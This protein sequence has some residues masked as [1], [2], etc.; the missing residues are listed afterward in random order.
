MVTAD[1]ERVTVTSWAAATPDV[2][3]QQLLDPAPPIGTL[4]WLRRLGAP[5]QYAPVGFK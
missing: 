1:R 5:Q 4:E 2:S 3:G